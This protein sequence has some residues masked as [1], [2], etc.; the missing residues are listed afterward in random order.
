MTLVNPQK[1]KVNLD[2]RLQ[3]GIYKSDKKWARIASFGNFSF[4]TMVCM[5]FA[6]QPYTMFRIRGGN[7][8]L[9]TQCRLSSTSNLAHA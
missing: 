3:K 6:F 5:I 9:N 4:A 2:K 7:S 1:T 8:F